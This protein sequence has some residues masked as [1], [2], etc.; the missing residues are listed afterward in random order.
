MLRYGLLIWVRD[1]DFSIGIRAS[2]MYNFVFMESG[3]TC[4][5]DGALH[6][7]C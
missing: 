7:G 2:S 3:K 1:D 6:H 5:H 4:G